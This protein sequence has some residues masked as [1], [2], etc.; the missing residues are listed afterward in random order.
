MK[1]VCRD[2][3]DEPVNPSLGEGWRVMCIFVL[4]LE[5]SDSM[6]DGQTG[7]LYKISGKNTEQNNPGLSFQV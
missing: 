4:L 3:S 5:D 6:E 1:M 7:F 2:F